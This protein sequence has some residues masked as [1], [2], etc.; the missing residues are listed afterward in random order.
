MD[1][2]KILLA[3]VG[4]FHINRRGRAFSWK[5]EVHIIAVVAELANSCGQAEGHFS[6]GMEFS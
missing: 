2:R 5:K 4:T 6:K 3:K 1:K